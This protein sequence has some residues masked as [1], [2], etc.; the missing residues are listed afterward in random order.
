[1]C[2][3]LFF[4]GR[5]SGIAVNTLLDLGI[6]AVALLLRA[7][8]GMDQQH[9]GMNTFAREL[10]G[11][12]RKQPA[13][14][15]HRRQN[16]ISGRRGRSW[17]RSV[18]C[19]ALPALM[20]LVEAQA[21]EPPKQVLI[22]YS[23]GREFSPFDVV[24]DSFRTELARRSHAAIEFH[25]AP[26]ETARSSQDENEQ[27]LADYLQARFSKHHLDLIVAMGGPAALF[28]NRHRELF[29]SDVPVIATMAQRRVEESGVRANIT[30]VPADVNLPGLV[31]DILQTLPATTNVVVVLGTSPFEQYWTEECKREF[32]PFTN[33][34]EFT[35]FNDLSLDRMC[36]EVRV[37]PPHSA[38]LFGALVTDADG[39]PHEQETALA[40]LR[41]SANAPIFSPF[42]QQL[43]LGIVGGRLIS[44]E[45]WGR[46]AADAAL[47]ILSG[48]PASQIHPQPTRPGTPAY[49]WRELQRWGID[50][51]R[52][53]PGAEIRFREPTLWEQHKLTI[54][55][56]ITLILVEAALIA[57]LILQL[58]RRR[59]AEALAQESERAARELSGRLIHTQEEERS[60]IARDLHDD[61]SQRLALLSVEIDLLGPKA[62]A[63]DYAAKLQQLGE[64]ARDLAS[65]VHRLAYQL[66][67]AKL[68]QLGLVPAIGGLS[69][70]LSQKSGLKV[71][72]THNNVPRDL[73]AAAVRC[74]FRVAQESLHNVVRHSEAKAARIELAMQNGYL[75][76]LVSDAGKGFDLK[77]AGKRAGLGLLSMK[78]RVR[79]S[80]G[81]LEI[82]SEPGH[83]TRVELTIPLEKEKTVA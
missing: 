67:P 19:L 63:A 52:L 73:P 15:R 16:R 11:P 39:V 43:G 17:R 26:L 6:P 55:G 4:Q 79:L 2:S 18:V 77:A 1:M 41:A 34:I 20:C 38:I 51:D 31:E 48:T 44:N 46:R 8:F 74:V 57:G 75:R 61:F 76:L 83:G 49:D 69:R 68:D 22:L 14:K 58:R 81:T 64:H 10:R 36:R 60:R 27:P 23:F 24:A 66:H 53:P 80:R 82:H 40:A 32:A 30:V 47:R 13:M 71:E 72:F 28:V 37:L 42:E 56:G 45:M 33:R 78:E 21:A 5:E 35:Y 59:R 62:T 70:D 9:Q 29:R 3:I 65:D 25:E 54:L 7:I 12:V 50:L